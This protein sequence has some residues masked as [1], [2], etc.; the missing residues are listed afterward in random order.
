MSEINAAGLLYAVRPSGLF[1]VGVLGLLFILGLPA[2]TVYKTVDESGHATYSTTP[3][4]DG[5][6]AKVMMDEPAPLPGF[7]PPP[8]RKSSEE[9]GTASATPQIREV[10]YADMT[11]EELDAG[12]ETAREARIAPIR[13]REIALCKASRTDPEICDRYYHDLGEPR[14]NPNGTLSPRMFDDL[15]ECK[16]AEDERLRRAEPNPGER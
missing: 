2:Q 1:V 9:P 13:T 7:G 5:V 4:P 6:A 12:C 16:L 11:V 3:P 8:P 14:A 15:P 10:H